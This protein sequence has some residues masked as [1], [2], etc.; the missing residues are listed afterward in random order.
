MSQNQENW[1]TFF[2]TSKRL[3]EFQWNLQ[4]RCD[5]NMNN[6]MNNKIMIILKD[7]FFEKPQ[8]EGREGRNWPSAVLELKCKIYGLLYMRWAHAEIENDAKEFV[9]SW[10]SK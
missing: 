4:G 9:F 5:K 6:I 10:D 2:I 3:E 1:W 7:K 8:G